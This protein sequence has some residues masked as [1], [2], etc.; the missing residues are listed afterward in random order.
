MTLALSEGWAM[1]RSR[2]TVGA[3]AIMLV[4][5]DGATSA[6]SEPT[7]GAGGTIAAFS[8]GA[9]RNCAGDRLGAGATTEL[10]VS[11]LRDRSRVTFT[12]AGAITFNGRLGAVS[13]ERTPSNGGG[14]GLDLKASK[15][16]TAAVEEGSLRLGASTTCD[17]RELPRATRIV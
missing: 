15:F 3:G 7:L 8:S 16:A 4:F 1:V 10:S 14:P 17:A 13:A 11:P 2:V 6:C 12:G 5:K 9:R